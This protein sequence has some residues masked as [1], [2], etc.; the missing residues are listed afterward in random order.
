MEQDFFAKYGQGLLVLTMMV[1][2]Y[3][4]GTVWVFV[5][6]IVAVK[7]LYQFKSM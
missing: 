6:D 2:L 1:I 5:R 3:E 4:K 7:E